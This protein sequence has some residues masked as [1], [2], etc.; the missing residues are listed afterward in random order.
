MISMIY[1]IPNNII[2]ISYCIMFKK[3]MT[4]NILKYYYFQYL[5]SKNKRKTIYFKA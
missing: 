1:V 3:N 4:L 5:L 2:D